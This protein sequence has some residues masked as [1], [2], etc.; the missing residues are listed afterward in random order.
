LLGI[1]TPTGYS[2]EFNMLKLLLIFKKSPSRFVAGCM[3]VQP[4]HFNFEKVEM[5]WL[6]SENRR[7]GSIID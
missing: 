6:G 4:E 3:M 5:L 7:M 1:S 2:Y